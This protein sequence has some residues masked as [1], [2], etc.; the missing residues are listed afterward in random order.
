MTFVSPSYALKL[1]RSVLVLMLLLLVWLPLP[2]ASNQLWSMSIF[3]L[4][5]GVLA[6]LWGVSLLSTAQPSNALTSQSSSSQSSRLGWWLFALLMSLQAWVALQWWLGIT[7]DAARSHLYLLLGVS[8]SLLFVMAWH[9]FN[10]EKRIKLLLAALIIS[11]TFQAFFGS[12]MVLSSIEWLFGVPK[13]HYLGNAT[14]TFVNRNSMAGYLALTLACGIGLLLAMRDGEPF[15]WRN[16]LELILGP[17]ARIRLALIIMVI[18]LVMTHSRMGN[19]AF[20]TALMVVGVVF[21]LSQKTN[22]LRNGLIL[23]SI[24]LIDLLVISQFFG[25]DRLKNRLMNTE[26]AITQEAGELVFDINDLR[27]LAFTRMIPLAKEQPLT[28]YGAG[29]YEVLFIGHTGPHFGGHFDHAHNDYLQFWLEVGLI[30]MLPLGIFVALVLW[31][32]FKALLNRESA[33]KSGVGF[34][35]AMAVIAYLVHSFSDFNLQIPANAATLM[36][37]CA[38]AVRVNSLKR[39]RSRRRIA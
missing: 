21:V 34:G 14:G 24:L 6:L 28:G 11:G 2:K 36:V 30:G 33:F 20:M 37:V 23:V 32:A 5:V 3:I 17:K 10:T 25:L 9:V 7:L 27:G 4:V 39:R 31:Q 13:E 12:V 35:V 22:R 8:Y 38:I 15:R 1:E 19:V 26:V 16:V 29:S 18:G